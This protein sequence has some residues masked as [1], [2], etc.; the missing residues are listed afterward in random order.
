MCIFSL[1][2]CH[3]AFQRRRVFFFLHDVKIRQGKTLLKP[4]LLEDPEPDAGK[5]AAEGLTR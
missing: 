5:E 1:Q 2:E 4:S 3:Q